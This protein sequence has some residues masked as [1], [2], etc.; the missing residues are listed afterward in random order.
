MT[1]VN[2]AAGIWE[3]ANRRLVLAP[4]RYTPLWWVKGDLFLRSL[5][6]V[7]MFY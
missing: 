4:C 1:I 5:R 6:L 2:V 7:V 3:G